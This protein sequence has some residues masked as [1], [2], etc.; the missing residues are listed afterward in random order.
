MKDHE[1]EKDRQWHRSQ[2]TDTGAK[3]PHEQKQHNDDPDRTVA[4]GFDDVVDRRMNEVG[5]LEDAP[6]DIVFLASVG[7]LRDLRLRS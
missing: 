7:A 2:R 6:F 5:L 4:D 3:I 1:G